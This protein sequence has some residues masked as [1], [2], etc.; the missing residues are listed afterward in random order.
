MV[1]Q[2]EMRAAAA[3]A[4]CPGKSG[5]VSPMGLAIQISRPALSSHGGE[6]TR[7]SSVNCA[8]LLVL[9]RGKVSCPKRCQEMNKRPREEM[10]VNAVFGPPI[11]EVKMPAFKS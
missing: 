8:A 9:S 11:F 4:Q 6:Q 2:S 1:R 10:E 5:G 3:V 7:T